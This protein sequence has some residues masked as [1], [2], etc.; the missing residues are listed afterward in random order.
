MAVKHRRLPNGSYVP[1]DNVDANLEAAAT[2]IAVEPTAGK[3]APPPR[4]VRQRQI[5][6]LVELG[7][8][9]ETAAMVVDRLREIH[10]EEMS[11]ELFDHYN[12]PKYNEP[13]RQRIAESK[14]DNARM[15]AFETNYNAETGHPEYGYDEAGNAAKLGKVDIRNPS[16]GERHSSRSVYGS[17]AARRR[18]HARG[19]YTSEMDYANYPSDYDMPEETGRPFGGTEAVAPDFA[20]YTAPGPR[21]LDGRP[22]APAR[23]LS[24]EEAD[25][26]NL[27]KPGQLSQRD[28]DMMARGYVPVVTPNGVVY[29]VS[30]A[31]GGDGDG[32]L[33]PGGPGRAGD[34][35]PDMV[36]RGWVPVEMRSPDGQK[37]QVY[38]PGPEM[39]AKQAEDLKGRRAAYASKK[40]RMD[41]ERELERDAS[42]PAPPVLTLLACLVQKY[43]F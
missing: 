4:D 5:D 34:G 38:T 16:Q 32:P 20:D 1:V 39:K 28:R 2:P 22:P 18:S 13:L 11:P 37:V 27:R 42:G 8:D 15:A 35:R 24:A 30:A 43:K 33:F 41:S 19:G 7:D 25:A 12:T 26:Y 29:K 9:P 36:E 14:A 3:A 17:N 6:R 31:T 21:T 23:G 10:G 40:A